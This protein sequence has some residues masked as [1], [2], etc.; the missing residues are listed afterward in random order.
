[1][2]AQKMDNYS[3]YGK[4]NKINKHKIFTNQQ[5]NQQKQLKVH[6]RPETF[7]PAFPCQK[8]HH[9]LCGDAREPE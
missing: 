7:T 5:T 8:N 1:M 9:V 2:T 3:T 6:L 4:K